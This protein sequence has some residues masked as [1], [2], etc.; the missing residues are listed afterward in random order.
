MLWFLLSSYH[1][2]Y[3]DTVIAQIAYLFLFFGKTQQKDLSIEINHLWENNSK[4]QQFKRLS[5]PIWD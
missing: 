2:L 5:I 1:I 4:N 3:E